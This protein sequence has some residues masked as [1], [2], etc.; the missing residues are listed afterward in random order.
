MKKTLVL[1]AVLFGFI[2]CKENAVD[3]PS[4]LIAEDKM[5]DV[6]YDLSILDAIKY[7][8]P[9]SLETYKVSPSQYIYKKYKIDS[10]QFAQSNIYYA[11]NY[12]DYKEMYD[13]VIKRIDAK[14]IVLDSLVARE[15]KKQA[16]IKADSLKLSKDTLIKK[17]VLLLKKM[18]SVRR[19]NKDTLRIQ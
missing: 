11:S 3:K 4:K 16:K 19:K 5:I 10:A 13:E 18:K 1:F 2:S 9:A 6:M 8:N 15:D 12:T 14:K 17:E 7:Q